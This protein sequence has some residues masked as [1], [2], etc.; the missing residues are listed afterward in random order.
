MLWSTWPTG[1]GYHRVITRRAR[2]ERLI[3][4]AALRRLRRRR[5]RR[6]LGVSLAVLDV[7][8]VVVARRPVTRPRPVV[9]GRP[10]PGV[11]G[12]DR[13]ETTGGGAGDTTARAG[14]SRRFGRP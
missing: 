12:R 10:Q 5:C 11:R 1:P 6:G 7:I 9:S 14:R 13:R 3:A 4:C 8:L 2:A